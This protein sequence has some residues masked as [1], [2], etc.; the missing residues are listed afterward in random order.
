M[1]HE[2]ILSDKSSNPACENGSV[3]VR[4]KA[5]FIKRIVVHRDHCISFYTFPVFQLIRRADE[6]IH[7]MNTAGS[8]KQG[9]GTSQK[10]RHATIIRN[11]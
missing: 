5:A 3:A 11:D 6:P 9:I 4:K 7:I 8:R 1:A 2:H 10:T